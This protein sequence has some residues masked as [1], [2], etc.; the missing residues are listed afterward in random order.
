MTTKVAEKKKFKVTGIRQCEV[1]TIASLPPP[2]ELTLGATMCVTMFS[3]CAPLSFSQVSHDLEFRTE[4]F[5]YVTEFECIW[6]KI[7]ERKRYFIVS[8]AKY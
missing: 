2:I 7:L 1:H 4:L 5:I 6:C 8:C 3:K